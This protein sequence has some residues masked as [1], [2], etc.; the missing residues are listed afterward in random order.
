MGQ[1][2]SLIVVVTRKNGGA[3]QTRRFVRIKCL[4]PRSLF[5]EEGEFAPH[6]VWWVTELPDELLVLGAV[7]TFA[8]VDILF[9]EHLNDCRVEIS[10]DVIMFKWLVC[11]CPSSKFMG[12]IHSIQRG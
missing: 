12:T 1:T 5:T 2:G 9:E 8:S 4:G 11:D 3:M 7:V 10:P 6:G